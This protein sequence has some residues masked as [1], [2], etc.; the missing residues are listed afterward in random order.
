MTRF[1]SK[2]GQKCKHK[3]WLYKILGKIIDNLGDNI[4]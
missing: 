1:L 2:L 4:D 3:N